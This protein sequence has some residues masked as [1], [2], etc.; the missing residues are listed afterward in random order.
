MD[1]FTVVWASG[2]FSFL[3]NLLT[4]IVR[5]FFTLETAATSRKNG[6]RDG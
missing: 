6:P 3:L 5:F 1:D 2:K 4:L